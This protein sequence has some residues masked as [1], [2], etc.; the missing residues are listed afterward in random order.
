MPPY[1]RPKP[2]VESSR[3][4]TLAAEFS[5]TG[6]CRRDAEKKPPT[7]ARGLLWFESYGTRVGP[8][9]SCP[10]RFGLTD[11][12]ADD[13]GSVAVGTT[14]RSSA[15]NG[16]SRPAKPRQQAAPA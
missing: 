1:D 16:A 3:R 6:C 2:A 9:G 12:R 13:R 7:R 8:G 14:P 5:K 4:I 10:S 11:A 15:R